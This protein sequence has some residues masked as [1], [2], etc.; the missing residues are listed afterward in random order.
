MVEIVVQVEDALLKR[1]MVFFAQQISPTLSEKFGDRSLVLTDQE[2]L[3]KEAVY[4]GEEISFRNLYDRIEAFF[5]NQK[6]NEKAHF[7]LISDLLVERYNK[8]LADKHRSID[9]T[10]KEVQ[11]LAILA[12]KKGDWVPREEILAEIWGYQEGLETHTLETHIY[13]L[14]QKI[15]EAFGV[16]VI[17]TGEGAYA[18]KQGF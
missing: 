3:S 17:V 2:S 14:R 12:D 10:E 8:K 6:H 16:N 4:L 9:L 18:L 5:L 11:L 15:E 7:P 1:E 13:R